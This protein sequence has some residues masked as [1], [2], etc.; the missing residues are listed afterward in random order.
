MSYENAWWKNCLGRGVNS[1]R[2]LKSKAF[3]TKEQDVQVRR[4]VLY[5][6][7][8]QGRGRNAEGCVQERRGTVLNGSAAGGQPQGRGEKEMG[9]RWART[10]QARWTL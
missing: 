7:H 2:G 4:S 3:K 10:D 8:G 9:G 1:K 6:G 5:K